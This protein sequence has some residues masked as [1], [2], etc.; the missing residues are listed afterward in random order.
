MLR[1]LVA[2][3]GFIA[4]S[5]NAF[6]VQGYD[7][8]K[9]WDKAIVYVPGNFLTKTVDTVKTEKPLPTVILLHGCAGI[10]DHE[11]KWADF[12]KS[13]GFIAILPNSF[14]IPNREMNCNPS[15]HTRNMGKVPVNDLRP[16][17]AEYAML[18]AQEQTW[19]D[20]N[21]IFLMGHSEGGMGAYL[22]KELG[23]KGVIVSGYPCARRRIG[24][25]VT[26]PFLAL[27]WK[28]DPYFDTGDTIASLCSDKPFWK[29]RVDATELVFP[30]KGHD[31]AYENSAL[32]AVSRFLKDKKK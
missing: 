1:M 28:E 27:N 17:E 30:G 3:I 29:N 22:T 24:S 23:F 8:S 26:T 14:G 20:R 12:L 15:T 25:A 11:K 21:N 9:A 16:A 18:K 10:Q 32:E 7:V 13:K 19:V 31:T 5:A 2:L 4:T 6:L